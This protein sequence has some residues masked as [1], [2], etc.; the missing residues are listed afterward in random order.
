MQAEPCMAEAV[1]QETGGRAGTEHCG[2]GLP[3]YS[4]WGSSFTSKPVRTENKMLC[5]ATQD[6]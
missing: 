1:G 2:Q 3:K 4:L 5:V 6:N